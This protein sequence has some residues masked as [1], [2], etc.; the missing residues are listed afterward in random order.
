MEN[1]WE[2]V[3]FFSNVFSMRSLPKM[4]CGG[5]PR[6]GI[7]QSPATYVFGVM[8]EMDNH[9]MS[10]RLEGKVVISMTTPSTAIIGSGFSPV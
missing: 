7:M 6:V 8:R 4:L 2:I 1:V 9:D 10:G 3:D 5:M